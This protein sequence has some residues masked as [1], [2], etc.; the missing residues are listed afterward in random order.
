MSHSTELSAGDDS[1]GKRLSTKNGEEK[2]SPVPGYLVLVRRARSTHT[3]RCLTCRSGVCWANNALSAA[4][5]GAYGTRLTLWRSN[6][7]S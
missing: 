2:T 7:A 6:K 4:T 3:E 1:P 5:D